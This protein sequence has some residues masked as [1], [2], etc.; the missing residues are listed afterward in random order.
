MYVQVVTYGLAGIGEAE[1]LDVANR[2]APRFSGMSGLL[3]KLWLGNTE[4][5]RYGAVYLWEDREAM[6]RFVRSDL[7]EA[8]NP[9]FDDVAVEDFNVLENLTAVTQPVLQLLEPKRQPPARTPRPTPSR[10]ASKAPAIS[11]GAGGARSGARSGAKKVPVASKAATKAPKKAPTKKATGTR[12]APAKATRTT[13][14]TRK[15]A[16]TAARKTAKKT[17]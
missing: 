5:N 9:D 13:G 2:V 8:F 7:F 17:R 1:Y 10:T 16:T 14:T 11:S 15:A 3:A 6:E 4:E 12:K